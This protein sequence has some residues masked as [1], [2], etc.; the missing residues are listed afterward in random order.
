MAEG[1]SPGCPLTRPRCSSSCSPWSVCDASL[2]TTR[3][4]CLPGY[5]GLSCSAPTMP[6]TFLPGGFVKYALAFQ[7]DLHHNSVQLRFRTREPRGQLFKAV[8]QHHNEYI[9]LDVSKTTVKNK[10]SCSNKQYCNK[11]LLIIF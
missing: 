1:T 3:C 5:S 8:D 2:S 4:R 9:I 11:K 6:S 10:S 7:P